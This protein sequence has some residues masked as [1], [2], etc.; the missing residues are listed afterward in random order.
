MIIVKRTCCSFLS[1]L[2]LTLMTSSCYAQQPVAEKEI[3]PT[4]TEVWEPEP[5]VVQSGETH[6]PPSDAIILLGD[7]GLG[8][9][10]AAY[11]DEAA[12]WDYSD[13]T[14]TVVKGKGDIKTKQKFTDVQL[15]IEWRSPQTIEGEGQGRGNSG[16]FFQ[17]IYEIQILDSY[18][19]RTYS[20]GQAGAIYKQHM[21][22]V[23][24]MN[25]TSEW[26]VYDII[27][28]APRFNK[29]GVKIS[30]AYVTVIHNGVVIHNHQEIYGTTEYRG[31]PKNSAHGAGSIKLQD[32]GNPVQFRN[33][34][35]REL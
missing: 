8:A 6:T 30:S 17:E 14:M 33:I 23:N 28:T 20:N 29:D 21:P 12:G 5:R 13:G 7:D 4:L 16:V 2:L 34:W 22:L 27:F 9:W 32:H 19:N 18:Q 1:A 10:Q 15:H 11:S 31:W 26:E 35:V 3:D 24:A 25:P